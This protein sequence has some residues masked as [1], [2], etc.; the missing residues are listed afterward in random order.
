[1]ARAAL[2]LAVVAAVVGLG[3]CGGMDMRGQRGGILGFAGPVGASGFSLRQGL[4]RRSSAPSN[5]CMNA[6]DDLVGDFKVGD[7]VKVVKECEAYHIFPR[8]PEA[9]KVEAGKKGV[10]SA[11]M[12][13]KFPNSTPNRPIIVQFTEPKKFKMHFECDEI[14]KDED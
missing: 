10:V 4:G 5:I 3:A 12:M 6:I 7:K 1:M 2:F 9:V 11:V 8:E 14:A 13:T